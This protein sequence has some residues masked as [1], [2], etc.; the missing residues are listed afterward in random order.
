MLEI[1]E[2]DYTA[3]EEADEEIIGLTAGE[4]QRR[5]KINGLNRLAGKKK[6]SAMK[7]FANQFRDF[8]VM[9]LLAATVISALLG[10]Y[11]DA[12]TIVIIVLNTLLRLLKK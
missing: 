4:A 10:D 9:I 7:I 5:L 11:Y 12:L 6:K 2:K 8:M 3:I 1:L